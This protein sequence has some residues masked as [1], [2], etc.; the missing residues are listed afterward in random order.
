M[1][2]S[3]CKIHLELNYTQDYLMPNID[4]HTKFNI[5]DKKHFFQ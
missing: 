4:V 1:Q 5:T 2:L 3:N